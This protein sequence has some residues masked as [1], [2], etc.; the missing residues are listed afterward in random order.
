MTKKLHQG[1]AKMIHFKGFASTELNILL[2]GA[3]TLSMQREYWRRRTD[4]QY[5]QSVSY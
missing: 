2:A 1:C 3:V 5:C 4:I